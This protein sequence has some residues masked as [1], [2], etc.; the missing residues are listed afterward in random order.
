MKGFAGFNHS[1]IE[2]AVIGQSYFSLPNRTTFPTFT[3]T[4]TEP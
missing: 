3:P 4:Q 1:E 2:T